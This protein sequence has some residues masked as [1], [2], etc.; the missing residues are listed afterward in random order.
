MTQKEPPVDG[1]EAEKNGGTEGKETGGETGGKE[2]RLNLT[3]VS[4]IFRFGV[5]LT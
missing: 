1:G 3:S 4:R 2:N 5:H